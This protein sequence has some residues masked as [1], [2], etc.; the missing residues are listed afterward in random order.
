M[1]HKHDTIDAIISCEL[2]ECVELLTVPRSNA[3]PEGDPNGP[4]DV[5]LKFDSPDDEETS[6]EANIFYEYGTGLFRVEWY[7]T[8]VGLVSSVHFD[9][10]R[11]ASGWLES[12]GFQDF[13]V[14][15]D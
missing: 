5:W 8:A 10:Y 3:N 7:N 12:C 11:R 6:H 15:E 2:S 13:T 14:H 4:L 9:T 1:T